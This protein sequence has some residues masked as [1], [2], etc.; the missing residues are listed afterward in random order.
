[1]MVKNTPQRN[2]LRYENMPFLAQWGFINL[3]HSMSKFSRRQDDNILFFQ[4]TSFDISC[5]SSALKGQ[6][7]LSEKNK[8]KQEKYF[9]L[10]SAQ[11]FTQSAKRYV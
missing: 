7:L 4:K 1:M 2:W 5:K 3:Y 9:N 6:N 10:S 11:N 8:K